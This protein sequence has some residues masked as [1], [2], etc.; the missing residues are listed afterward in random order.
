MTA[1]R[2]PRRIRS[3]PTAHDLRG[4]YAALPAGADL[5]TA[6][7]DDPYG[8]PADAPARLDRAEWTPPPKPRI[9]VIRSFRHDPL[10]RMHARGQ[11]G[12][13]EYLAGRAYQTLAETAAGRGGSAQSLWDGPSNP[14]GIAAVPVTDAMLRAGRRL[15]AV[16]IRLRARYG[17]E[18]MAVT[19]AVL[20]QHRELFR[21]QTGNL[22]FV[23]MLLR[24][25]LDEIGILLG[26]SHKGA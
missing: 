7:I 6:I 9:V 2:R 14:N 15:R 22:R 4:Q 19:R 24:Q 1:T 20:L 17:S 21:V 13:A 23:G 12:E 11:V 10:G 25:C 3:K 8:P 18:G 26:L 16:D 5:A